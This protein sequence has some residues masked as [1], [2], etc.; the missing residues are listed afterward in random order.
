MAAFD[1]QFAHDTLLGLA[2]AAYLQNLNPPTDLPTGY[3]LVGQ[4]TAD[5]AIAAQLMA[6]AP[7]Q[8]Q[9]LLMT[10]GIRSRVWLGC[11][12]CRRR[13]RDRCLPW[14]SIRRRLAA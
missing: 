1:P 12:K 13:Y 10:C 14:D 9:Q 3:E 2:E 8:H 6:A 7:A 4:L 11:S 5:P